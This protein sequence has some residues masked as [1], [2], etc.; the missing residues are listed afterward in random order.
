LRGDEFHTGIDPAIRLF[1]PITI[2]KPDG[3]DESIGIDDEPFSPLPIGD[4]NVIIVSPLGNFCRV[5]G[6]ISLFFTCI[7]HPVPYTLAILTPKICQTI[8]EKNLFRY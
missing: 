3:F 5:I 7:L 2:E 1:C 8:H 6:Y 4:G